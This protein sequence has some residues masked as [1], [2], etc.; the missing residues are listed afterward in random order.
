M[1]T[2]Y[3]RGPSNPLSNLYPFHFLWK[4][5]RFGSLEAA[6]QWEKACHLG[7]WQAAE[8][9]MFNPDPTFSTMRLG[10]Q[11]PTTASWESK[12]LH[13]MYHLLLQ[14]YS[15]CEDYREA[16]HDA[17]NF[18]EDTCHPFWGRGSHG[19]GLNWMGRLHWE[20]K[21]RGKNVLILGSSH[22][23]D[24]APY[25]RKALGGKGPFHVDDQPLPGATVARVMDWISKHY[26]RVLQ[27][28]VIFLLI[29]S[30]DFFSKQGVHKAGGKSVCNSLRDLFTFIRESAPTINLIRT[31][32]LPRCSIGKNGKGFFKKQCQETAFCNDICTFDVHLP[33]LWKSRRSGNPRYFSPD[34]VHLN[35]KGKHL[36]ADAWSKM[37]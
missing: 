37:V 25:L 20:V 27:Y 30:N 29:G 16:L 19:D 31:E 1:D 3:F 18:I 36:V 14:K 13:I 5:T 26:L 11:L 15:Q 22:A 33:Q 17:S 32:V 35:V 12:K 21:E 6:Y 24:M 23:R 28:D 7:L 10:Q 4:D 9:I 2:S 34:C 8:G